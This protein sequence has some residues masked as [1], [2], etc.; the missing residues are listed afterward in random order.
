MK[1]SEVIAI[2]SAINGCTFASMDTETMPKRGLLKVMKGERV[3]LFTNKKS[4]GYENMVRR[5]LEQA[6]RD[7][8]SF[9]VGDLPWGERVPETPLILH[10]GVYYLQSVLLYPGKSEY[11]I[12]GLTVEPSAFGLRERV[13]P[14]L[15]N[16]YKLESISRIT[17]LGETIGGS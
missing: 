6:G 16:A 8:E 2:L 3:I 15:V 1:L 17:L 5:R 12:G 14:V 11:S 4:S 9:K 10:K 7:P 13:N